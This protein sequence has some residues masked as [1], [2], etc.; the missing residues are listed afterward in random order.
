MRARLITS[1]LVLLTACVQEQRYAIENG[2]VA[3]TEDAEPAFVN[4]DEDEIFI[5]TREFDLQIKPAS[6]QRLDMLGR[7]AQGK[8]LPFPRMPHVELHDLEIQVDYVLANQSDE[9][10]TATFILNGRN[11]FHL[12]TP[13]PED[14]SQWERRFALA[15]KQR[16]HGTITELELDEIAVDLATV[17][18]GAPNSNEVVH[19][20]S[21]SSRDERAKAFIPAVIPGLVG[22]NAGI[23][24]TRAANVVLEISVRV[25]DLGGRAAARGE[26]RWDLPEPTPFVPVS[27][28]EEQ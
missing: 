28:E 24:A 10:V 8:N 2:A 6:Q 11:E 27:E 4:D 9:E 20:N 3:L 25:Q 22:L 23:V 5:V 18:N 19:V 13:G 1:T 14:F 17:V 21:Q 16:V 7:A 12:Y 26:K 15:P